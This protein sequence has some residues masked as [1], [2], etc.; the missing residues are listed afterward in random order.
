MTDTPATLDTDLMKQVNRRFITGVTVVTAMDGETPKGLAVNAFASVTVSPAVILVCVAKTSSTHDILFRA[1][2]FA[3]NLLAGDQSGVAQR[4]AT[5]S[6]DKFAD[7]L[8]HYGDHGMPILDGTCA[9]LEAEISARVRTST[10]TV[11]FGD[12]LAAHSDEA[13]PLIYAG[14]QFFDGGALQP[15]TE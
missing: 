5:K 7:I 2:R 12:V 10:H 14:S 9:H 4:F 11:F 1:Q 13:A 6:A 3:V 8:W 15:V